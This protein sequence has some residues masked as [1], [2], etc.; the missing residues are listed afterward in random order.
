MNRDD[1]EDMIG[2]TGPVDRVRFFFGVEGGG[3]GILFTKV[4]L[5]RR[6]DNDATNGSGDE[7]RD[8]GA[9]SDRIP[10]RY[11]RLL[12]LPPYRVIILDGAIF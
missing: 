4:D 9:R 3:G 5:T 12:G 8:N 1:T 6:F 11:C 10:V 2:E 7:E